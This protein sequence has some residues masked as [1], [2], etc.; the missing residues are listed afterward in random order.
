MVG[1][2]SVGY[3]LVVAQSLAVPARDS[4]LDSLSS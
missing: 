1:Y 4:G 2:P 3:P